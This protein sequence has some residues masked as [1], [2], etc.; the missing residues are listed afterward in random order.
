MKRE[1]PP[2]CALLCCVAVSACNIGDLSFRN[3]HRVQV[4]EPAERVTLPLP[5]TVRWTV[6]DFHVTG[7][8]GS[9]DRQSG[10]FAVFFDSTPMPPG[11]SMAWVANQDQSCAHTPGCPDA[12]WLAFRGIYTTSNTYVTVAN[13]AD[14][15]TPSSVDSRRRGPEGHRATI[16]L[17]N[18]EGDRIGESAFTVNFFLDR[19]SP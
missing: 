16:V 7:P 15:R 18:G 2:L 12:D 17:L 13:L 14:T 8:S 10:Y 11:E 4:S 5:V 3:D 1:W 19:G 9:P 6:K